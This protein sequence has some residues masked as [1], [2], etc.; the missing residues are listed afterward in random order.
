[1]KEFGKS[2][3]KNIFG[4]TIKYND[5]EYEAEFLISGYKI[6]AQLLNIKIFNLKGDIKFNIV[7]NEL[8]SIEY[9]Q[10]LELDFNNLIIKI[11]NILK[12]RI[13]ILNYTQLQNKL[14]KWIKNGAIYINYDFFENSIEIIIVSTIQYDIFG[15]D[16]GMKYKII[17]LGNE[18]SSF[19]KE[20]IMNIIKHE[21]PFLYRI[22]SIIPFELIKET[23]IT[24]NYFFLI[25]L[26]IV[27]I[28][29]IFLNIIPFAY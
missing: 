4:I 18:Q 26:I 2:L 20:I 5:N 28:I 12:G 13:N 16:V 17:L 25:R 21:S 22:V 24:Y 7:D 3:T 11:I 1:M 10:K 9:G 19:I 15:T 23:M 27:Y 8:E 14:G 6:N 29:I